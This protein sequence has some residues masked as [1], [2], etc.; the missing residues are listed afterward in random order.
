M[1]GVT[2]IADLKPLNIIRQFYSTTVFPRDL[3][4]THT[5]LPLSNTDNIINIAFTFLYT[6]KSTGRCLHIHHKNNIE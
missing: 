4:D 1:G 3:D 2:D 5:F 6:Q